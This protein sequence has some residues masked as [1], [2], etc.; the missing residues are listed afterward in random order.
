MDLPE[1]NALPRG[2][3]DMTEETPFPATPSIR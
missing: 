3:G 2:G 1:S